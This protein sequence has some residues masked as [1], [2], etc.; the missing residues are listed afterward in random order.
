MKDKGLVI[1]V[2]VVA[3]A[4][5]VGIFTL[6]KPRAVKVTAA[7]IQAAQKAGPA[8]AAGKAGKAALAAPAKKAISKDMGALTV[9]MAGRKDRDV[10][11]RAKVFKAVDSKSS[12]FSG[13]ITTNRMSELAPGTYDIEIET[14]PAKIYKGINVAKG[15]ETLEDLGSVIGS[16]EIKA[17]GSSNRPASYPVKIFHANSGAAAAGGSTNRPI[18]IVAGAYDLEIGSAPKQVKK[19]VKIEAGKETVL[20]IGIPGAILVKAVDDTG[21]EAKGSVRIKKAGDQE[22]VSSAV[23]N[24]PFDIAE[25][26][27]T[28]ESVTS[29][30]VKKSD[31]KVVPGQETVVELV[32]PAAP[33][34]APRPALPLK[35]AAPAAAAAPAK[36]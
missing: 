30:S 20:D 1:G 35:P 7:G 13:T 17:V 32:L 6:A 26:V 22:I 11:L 29:P 31:V 8:V 34:P 16:I 9:K 12:V 36:K 15:R 25:G 3:V 14:V 27:Y 2:A 33:V 18:D 10:S 21:K 4:V 23:I 24:R 5:V 28:V 19:G